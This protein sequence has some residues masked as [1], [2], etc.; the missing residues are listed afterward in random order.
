MERPGALEFSY[1]TRRPLVSRSGEGTRTSISQATFHL[2]RPAKPDTSS[3][4][5][6][7][8]D[9]DAELDLD[10]YLDLDPNVAQALV[11][12]LVLGIRHIPRASLNHR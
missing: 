11:Q 3:W 6:L 5:G 9:L 8:R 1:L 10:V 2:A 4:P 7:E 12:I